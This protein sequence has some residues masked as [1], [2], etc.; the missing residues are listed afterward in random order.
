[1]VSKML[2]IESFQ[3]SNRF[4]PRFNTHAKPWKITSMKQPQDAGVSMLS[5]LQV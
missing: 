1:M 3:E 5:S 2:E 4:A